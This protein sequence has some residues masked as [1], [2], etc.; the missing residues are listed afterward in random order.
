MSAVAALVAGEAL[1]VRERRVEGPGPA[2]VVVVVGRRPAEL[3]DALQV[4]LDRVGDVV[5][6]LVLV[7][8]AVRAALAARAVVGDDHDDRV[9][10]L[11]RLLEVVE[12]P[13]DLVVGVGDEAGV[14]LGHAGEEALLVV[15][16][17]VPGPHEVELRPRLPVGTGDPVRLSVRVDRRE[18]DVLGQEAELLLAG[19]DALADRLVALVEAPLVRVRPLLEDVVRRVRAA[20]AEVHEPGLVGIDRLRVA[21][22]LDR[23]VGQVL[24]EVVAVLGLRRLLDRMV[25]LDEVRIPLVRLAAEEAVEAL[26]AAAERPAPLPGGHVRLLAGGEVPLADRVRVPAALV[27]HLGDRPVLERDAGREPGEPC[28][29]LGD[30]RHVVARSRC[31]R[32]GGSSASAS[33]ARS[34]GSS[35]SGCR[36]RR[37][38]ASSASR[39][40]RRRRPWRRSRRRPRRSSG[41]SARP[42]APAAAGTAPSRASS[43]GCRG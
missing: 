29:R 4:L 35:R 20:R 34:C 14:D 26:E 2:G 23:L 8:G 36:R 18:L 5:E 13:P 42:R 33:R 7:E 6:E 39:S 12:E 21:H 11:A 17:R 30:A 10:E 22:E 32:S 9:V 15:G 24:R 38:G 28:R 16:E 3:V 43:R 27:Q 1:P 25:V 19:E 41:R 31:A 40:A 37:S